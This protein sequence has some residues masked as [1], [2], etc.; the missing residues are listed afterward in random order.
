MTESL[1]ASRPIAWLQ[2][3]EA[4]A[5]GF[6][7]VFELASDPLLEVDSD[8]VAP[9]DSLAAL[10]PDFELRLSVMYQPEPLNTMPT[11]CGTRLIS[12]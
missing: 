1:G 5:A 11:G 6:L 4:V 2:L 9:F 8:L 10:D 12:P 7:S 3:L